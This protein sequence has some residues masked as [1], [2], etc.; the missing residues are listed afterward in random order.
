[1]KAAGVAD[2][3]IADDVVQRHRRLATS[4]WQE[5]SSPACSGT[6]SPG[7]SPTGSTCGGTNCVVDAACAS[8]LSAPSTWPGWNCRPA[9][10]TSSSP[11]GCDTFN[12]IFM[13]MCFS[14]TP[15]LSPTGDAKP[16]DADGDGTILGEGLG[17]RRAEAPRRRRA[18]RR[19]ASTPCSRASARRAT[20]RGTRSTPRRPTGRCGACGPPTDLA[21][22]TPG[23]DRTG[24][25]PRHRH[26]GRRRGRG[27]GAGRSVP[28]ARSR[29]GDRGVPLGSVK[30]QIGHTKAAAGAAGLIKAALALYNKVL[31]PTIKVKKPVEP[32]QPRRLAVLREHRKAAVAAAGRAPAAGRA[33]SA[34]G[35]GGSQLPRGPRGAQPAR[36]PARTGTAR[37]DRRAR[38]AD[39]AADLARQLNEFPATVSVER[40]V[41]PGRRRPAAAIPTGRTRAA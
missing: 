26:E 7:G 3:D 28:R 27:D 20:A 29:S 32:L 41:A 40:G 2:K 24:R 5:N 33:V 21:G 17:R 8:S 25:G 31:P 35:F 12:D 13:Y 39:T 37:A 38:P 10:P 16:F 15:A 18:R 34:F 14:K 22:V 6:S 4:P 1:M 30:S 11:A 19:H 9:G 36:S 23:H